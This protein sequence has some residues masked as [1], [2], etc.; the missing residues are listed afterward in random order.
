MSADRRAW[1]KRFFFQSS[2]WLMHITILT[3][4]HM[5]CLKTNNLFHK[6]LSRSVFF[7]F[8][9]LN[10][11][12]CEK[13]LLAVHQNDFLFFSGT[14]RGYISHKR[15]S[16]CVLDKRVWEE[17]MWAISR[18]GAQVTLHVLPLAPS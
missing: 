18:P 8:Q 12:V 6:L 9:I 13:G 7:S 10:S 16:D 11:S 1:F 14:Q 5:L 17:V 2:F 3:C 15:P 4:V